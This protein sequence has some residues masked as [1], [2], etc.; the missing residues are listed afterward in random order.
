M[1]DFAGR[2]QS[3]YQSVPGIISSIAVGATEADLAQKK[4]QI[5]LIES[6]LYEHDPKTG[7]LDYSK[8]A[9]N[10]QMK[11]DVNL[12]P[13]NGKSIGKIEASLDLP[14]VLLIPPKALAID[15]VHV[16]G[17]MA[18]HSSVQD[19]KSLSAK[20]GISGEGKVGY[21]PF[22]VSVKVSGE[23][24]QSET[25]KRASDYRARMNWSM[26]MKQEPMSEAFQRT[27]DGVT[28]EVVDTGMNMFAQII[29]EQV[30][31]AAKSAGLNPPAP[32][33]TTVPAK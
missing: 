29:R 9:A 21:G 1:G 24:S 3:Y 7:K 27:V 26:D 13:I 28:R 25:S 22:S 10:M 14:P 32:D 17:S 12:P 31:A 23:A 15:N 33:E 18:V 16:E 20:E 2:E 5:G 4:A 8:P 11:M 19:T 30:E 6:M